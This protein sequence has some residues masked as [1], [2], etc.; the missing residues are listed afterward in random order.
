MKNIFLWQKTEFLATVTFH[1]FL[2]LYSS[3]SYILNKLKIDLCL[4]SLGCKTDRNMET[5]SYSAPL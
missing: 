4:S 5:F 1:L 2:K 3:V